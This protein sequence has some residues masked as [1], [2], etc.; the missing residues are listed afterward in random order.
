MFKPLVM[1]AAASAALLTTGCGTSMPTGPIGAGPAVASPIA[2]PQ[3]W[4]GASCSAGR[5][6]FQATQ[7]PKLSSGAGI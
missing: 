1:T 6:S 3:A 2:T 7:G 5:E 4:T